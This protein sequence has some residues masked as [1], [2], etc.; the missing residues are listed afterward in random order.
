LLRVGQAVTEVNA[1][2]FDAA[3]GFRGCLPG[4]HEMLRRQGLLAGRWCL[5]PREELSPGQRQAIDRVCRDYPHLADTGFVAR[6]RDRW[7]S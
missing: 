6:H 5:D 1:A 4:I 7:L 2:V 3:N